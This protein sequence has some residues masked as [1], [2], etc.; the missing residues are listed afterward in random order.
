MSHLLDSGHE[1]RLHSLVDLNERTAAAPAVEVGDTADHDLVEKQRTV[2]DLDRS[3]EKT[4]KIV[5]VS[6]VQKR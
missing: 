6:G 5:N 3:R 4:S 2:V 1:H